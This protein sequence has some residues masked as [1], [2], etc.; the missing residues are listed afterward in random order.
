MKS[1]YTATEFA[2]G[3]K[4]IHNEHDANCKLR[5][6]T[7]KCV[8]LNMTKLSD[9][10]A[11]NSSDGPLVDDGAKH[12]AIGLVELLLIEDLLPGDATDLDPIFSSLGGPRW[13][14]TLDTRNM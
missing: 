12:S 14:H 7:K 8:T 13:F 9:C 3:L 6:K 1:I 2:I 4:N 5:N 10:K 11:V